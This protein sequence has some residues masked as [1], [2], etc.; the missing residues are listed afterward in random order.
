MAT[1]VVPGGGKCRRYRE[2]KQGSEENLLHAKNVA[3]TCMRGREDVQAVFD[4]LHQERK[5]GAI[6]QNAIFAIHRKR[7]YHESRLEVSIR[8]PY[9]LPLPD[10]LKPWKVKIFDNEL[11]FEEPHVTIIFKTTRWR[12]SLRG[13]RFLDPQPDPNDV[14]HEVLAKID[15]EFQNLCNE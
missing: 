8:M 6:E 11:L 1:V 4:V 10:S 3:P 13:R 12:F 5:Q 7:A 2:N 14:R 9:D 15:E